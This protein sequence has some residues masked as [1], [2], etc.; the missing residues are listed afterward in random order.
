MINE[1]SAGDKPS[2]EETE[3]DLEDNSSL[4]TAKNIITKGTC[5]ACD[6]KN[7]DIHSV[8]IQCW[9]CK[10]YFHAYNCIPECDVTCKTSFDST[11]RKAVTNSAPYDKKFGRLL[12]ACEYCLTVRENQRA[13]EDSNKVALLERKLDTMQEMF[14][15]ELSELRAVF[16]EQLDNSRSDHSLSSSSTT[17]LDASQDVTNKWDD[18]SKVNSMKQMLI[19]KN[20]SDGTSIC[21]S[22]LEKICADKVTE[23]CESFKGQRLV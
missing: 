23:V 7:L 18:A 12:F 16:K 21:K 9:W 5:S 15:K 11:I 14:M 1:E 22:E 17:S 8:G 3:K 10:L 20:N 6:T 4:N 19:I 13:N 2:S